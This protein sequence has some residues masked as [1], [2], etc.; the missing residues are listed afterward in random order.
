MDEAVR[1][2]PLAPDDAKADA[3]YRDCIDTA[4]KLLEE[5][6][7]HLVRNFQFV[8]FSE[9]YTKNIVASLIFRFSFTIL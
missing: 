6:R 5:D 8:Y 9:F 3:K 2:F 1:L 4:E 7:K